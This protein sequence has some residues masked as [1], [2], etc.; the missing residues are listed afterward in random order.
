MSSVLRRRTSGEHD[1]ISRKTPPTLTSL[2]VMSERR[3][4]RRLKRDGGWAVSG[5][6]LSWR[7]TQTRRADMMVRLRD[8]LECDTRRGVEDRARECIR[9]SLTST[10]VW[11]PS[12]EGINRAVPGGTDVSLLWQGAFLIWIPSRGYTRHDQVTPASAAPD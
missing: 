12:E 3:W 11:S 4:S 6:L 8:H 9:T 5:L 2:S 1:V 7:A 10:S